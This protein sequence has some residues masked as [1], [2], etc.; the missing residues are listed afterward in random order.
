[1][2]EGKRSARWA[3][4]LAGA[5]L[6]PAVFHAQP[7][8]K[9]PAAKTAPAVNKQAFAVLQQAASLVAQVPPPEKD[10]DQSRVQLLSSL[11]AEQWRAGDLAGARKSFDEALRL[12]KRIKLGP[13][14][15]EGGSEAVEAVAKSRARVGD[16]AGVRQ[17][18]PLLSDFKKDYSE[19]ARRSSTLGELARA[20]ILLGDLAA[21]A[22][23]VEKIK[24]ESERKYARMDLMQAYVRRG[25]EAKAK[26]ILG[27]FGPDDKNFAA[28]RFVDGL[29]A[30]GKTAEAIA[31]AAGIPAPPPPDASAWFTPFDAKAGA[32]GDIARAQARS[33]DI[34]GAL[35]TISAMPDDDNKV[36]ALLALLKAQRKA[37]DAAGAERTYALC[38]ASREKYDKENHGIDMS[39]AATYWQNAVRLEAYSEKWDQARKAAE[40][41]LVKQPMF[42]R[43][44]LDS[45]VESYGEAKNYAAAVEATKSAAPADRVRL[46]YRAARAQAQDGKEAD[47]LIWVGEESSPEMKAN[48]LIAI[49]QGILNRDR[50]EHLD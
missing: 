38:V 41:A 10:Y 39:H 16:A 35:L 25:D 27:T 22:A 49:A 46:V 4:V 32:Q 19:T 8:A 37:G 17:V 26:A 20:Q 13:A 2:S 45:L 24:S 15:M 50:K 28:M 31:M 21:A 44:A 30:A 1:M 34:A 42:G 18:L 23:T 12:A 47:A 40:D 48:A 14:A 11:G 7:K 36:G 29:L 5:C 6:L 33:G 3:G 43:F 9:A